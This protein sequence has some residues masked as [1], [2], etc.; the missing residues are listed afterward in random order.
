M[1][2]A[3]ETLVTSLRNLK[4]TISNED[5]IICF[6]NYPKENETLKGLLNSAISYIESFQSEQVE[7]N[8]T[9]TPAQLIEHIANFIKKGPSI[10]SD[11]TKTEIEHF[12]RTGIQ[13]ANYCISIPNKKNETRA[14]SPKFIEEELKKVKKKRDYIISQIKYKEG[15]NANPQEIHNLKETLNDL[16]KQ[17]ESLNKEKVDSI[18]DDLIEKDWEQRINDSFIY[19]QEETH[20]LE[21]RIESLDREYHLFLYA[22]PLIFIFIIIW[23]CNLYGLLI[24]LE[25]INHI[26]QL[27]S[28]YLPV[29]I[30]IALVWICIVQ[31]NRAS[32]LL[33]TLGEELFR[34]KYLQGLLLTIN[35]LSDNP[36]TAIER[37][38]KAVNAMVNSYLRQTEK[39]FIDK[40]HTINESKDAVIQNDNVLQIIKTLLDNTVK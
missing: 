13:I 10:T 16:E 25:N 32:R 18:G 1:L 5:S 15:I 17:I 24:D 7:Y 38:N 20:N 39:R 3:K 30:F 37:I 35:R 28:Y 6:E 33:I 8:Y 14:I 23:L 21:L 36:Q 40:H 29:P 4:Q 9:N 19:L 34:I 27:F 31:K 11:E 12:L 26:S 22:L 2:I